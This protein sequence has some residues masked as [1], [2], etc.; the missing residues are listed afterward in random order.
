MKAPETPDGEVYADLQRST[1]NVNL[2]IFVVAAM[3]PT[4]KLNIV[5]I[6]D[7]Q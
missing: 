7:R 6:L 1:S 2:R 5:N 3:D 4:D